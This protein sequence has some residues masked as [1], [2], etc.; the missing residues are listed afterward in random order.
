MLTRRVSF[1]PDPP[2]LSIGKGRVAVPTEHRKVVYDETPP[3]KMIGY[4]VPNRNVKGKPRGYACSVADVERK[5]G[6]T[7][8]PELQGC[9][10]LKAT[11]DA[12]AWDWSKSQARRAAIP[13]A[14]TRV[15]RARS[16]AG[17]RER[18]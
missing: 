7:F 17:R 2:A 4:I 12:S 6:L 11:F 1:A 14:R 9:D 8:F 15:C 18:K 5:T 16:A 13:V 3:A 10:A